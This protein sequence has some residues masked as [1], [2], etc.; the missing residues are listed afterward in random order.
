M[1]MRKPTGPDGKAPE[2]PVGPGPAVP[3]DPS[4]WDRRL[5]EERERRAKILAL[6]GKE[7]E[8]AARP[9]PIPPSAGLFGGEAAGPTA[10]PQAPE[11]RAA[12]AAASAGPGFE[13]RMDR[14]ARAM[15][16]ARQRRAETDPR[17]PH[18]SDP[19]RRPV[20]PRGVE[21]RGVEPRQKPRA[22]AMPSDRTVARPAAAPAAADPLPAAHRSR[23][24]PALALGLAA[25][26]GLAGGAYLFGARNTAPEVEVVALADPETGATATG[27]AQPAQDQPPDRPSA[28]APD[29]P[30]GRLPAL[31]AAAMPT[32]PQGPL[33]ADLPAPPDIAAAPTTAPVEASALADPASDMVIPTAPA[34]PQPTPRP[35]GTLAAGAAP[36][37]PTAP[38]VPPDPATAATATDPAAQADTAAVAPVEPVVAD[39]AAFRLRVSAPT[40]A[41][42]AEVEAVGTVLAGAGF[43]GV[44]TQRV[45][46]TV[47]RTH[48]RYYN[49]ED[50]AAAQAIA[51]RLGV[52]ARDFTGY[53]PKPAAGT[54]EVWI[55]GTAPGGTARG[56]RTAQ[57]QAS[58]PP[59]PARAVQEIGQAVR[60]LV[61]TFPANEQR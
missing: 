22:P 18:E 40:S 25:A 34:D 5:A 1:V 10:P 61:E 32:P 51:G 47:S 23:L 50:A 3:Y 12:P 56:T 44:A 26:A 17:P 14:I 16:T 48:L 30:P 52:E 53:R 8:A 59:S 7:G 24:V 2:T 4:E 27:V 39:P 35:G 55:A 43:P 28:M 6:R 37:D 31:E 38:V 60:T 41:S 33:V 20:E 58:Q 42:A 11:R 57:P 54:I 29:V 49:P 9:V 46:F 36:V 21:P 15:E 19:V 45:G 13:T